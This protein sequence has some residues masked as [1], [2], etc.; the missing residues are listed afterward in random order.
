LLSEAC[1]GEPAGRVQIPHIADSQHIGTFTKCWDFKR[2]ANGLWRMAYGTDM[3]AWPI[4]YGTDLGRHCC[5]FPQMLLSSCS[6]YTLS[7]IGSCQRASRGPMLGRPANTELLHAGFERGGV[8][9][10]NFGGPFFSTDAPSGLIEDGQDM[11]AFNVFQLC[12]GSS[13]GTF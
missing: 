4:A 3:R 1:A 9:A 8:E 12:E 10:E 5:S 2:G 11:R 13:P 7:A 6:C